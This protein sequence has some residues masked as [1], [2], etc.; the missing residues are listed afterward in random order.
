MALEAPLRSSTGNLR[1]P[2][3]SFADMSASD[4]E[5]FRPSRVVYD[6]NHALDLLLARTVADLT[7]FQFLSSTFDRLFYPS[8]KLRQQ[9]LLQF[10]APIKS[11]RHCRP[12]T[13][14]IERHRDNRD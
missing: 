9:N 11:K 10:D 2:F 1:F 14:D 7:N 13:G 5:G 4:N 6:K 8:P 12:I 3:G